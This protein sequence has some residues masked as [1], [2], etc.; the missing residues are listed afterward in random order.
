MQDE[1][2]SSAVGLRFGFGGGRD[3]RRLSR[4][5]LCLGI[6]VLLYGRRL[7]ARGVAGSS[8]VC[9]CVCLGF[10]CRQQIRS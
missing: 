3:L 6:L 10:R 9:V 5:D 1:D 7:A 8:A 4:L 2:I